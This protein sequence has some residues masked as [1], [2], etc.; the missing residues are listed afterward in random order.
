MPAS[1]LSPLIHLAR[2]RKLGYLKLVFR[3]IVIPTAEKKADENILIT[4]VGV[5]KKILTVEMQEINALSAQL[6]FRV[7]LVVGAVGRESP[8]SRGRCPRD[9]VV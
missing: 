9:T 3:S 1:N 7:F 6:G 8:F 5:P 2:P 4:S